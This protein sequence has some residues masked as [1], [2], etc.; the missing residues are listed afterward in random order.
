M[1]EYIEKAI[2][3]LTYG[4]FSEQR[5]KVAKLLQRID[6]LEAKVKELEAENTY[7]KERC[8]QTPIPSFDGGLSKEVGHNG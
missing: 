3:I 5:D 6:E 4:T 7:L 1:S 8:K 2:H